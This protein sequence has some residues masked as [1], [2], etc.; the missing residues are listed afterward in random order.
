MGNFWKPFVQLCHAVFMG[1]AVAIASGTPVVAQ[2]GLSLCQP[3]QTGEFLVLVF[4]PSQP[5]QTEVRNQVTQTLP[6]QQAIACEYNGNVLS[7][8]GGFTTLEAATQWSEYFGEAVGLP[9]MVITPT[10][11]DLSA[12]AVLPPNGMP[13]AAQANPVP[14]SVVAATPASFQ[15]RP[16]QGGFGLLVDYGSDWAIATR[17]KALTNQAVGLVVYGGRGYLLAA[18]TEDATQ[19]TELLNRLNQNGLGAIAV[20]ADQL[21]LLKADINP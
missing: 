1:S 6:D 11:S 3:P 19:L 13:A 16:L 20:P 17:L 14:P 7:R 8:V 21:I 4:T 15:P 10:D 9:L 18:Q 2:R 12:A 5:L